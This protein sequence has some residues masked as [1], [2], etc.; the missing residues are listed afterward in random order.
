VLSDAAA[1]VLSMTLASATPPV[2]R[3]TASDIPGRLRELGLSSVVKLGADPKHVKHLAKVRV[4]L[5]VPSL[6]SIVVA[7]T[8]ATI[9]GAYGTVVTTTHVRSRDLMEDPFATTLA[10]IDPAAVA[11][12]KEKVI[13]G[14]GQVHVLPRWI[15]D[16]Q[17]AALQVF[18]HELLGGRL[19][20]P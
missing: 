10:D 4:K 5:S 11:V 12:S 14:P 3:A 8:D 20:R 19:D 1:K 6:E 16:H 15:S 18:L 7:M 2:L 9:G 17:L 13:V